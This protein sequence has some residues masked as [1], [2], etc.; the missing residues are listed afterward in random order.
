MDLSYILNS[1]G[2]DQIALAIRALPNATQDAAD[3]ANAAAQTATEA[4][5]AIDAK[6]ASKIDDTAGIGDTGKTWSADKLFNVVLTESA[7]QALITLFQDALYTQDH[8]ETI[9]T[10]MN[11]W[12]LAGDVIIQDG[13]ILTILELEN[14]PT[15]EN[16]SITIM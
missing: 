3:N 14:T 13:N 1:P 5:E 10:L 16:D 8:T 2:V 15:V 12:G 6:I 4:A 11:E 9:R 7:K